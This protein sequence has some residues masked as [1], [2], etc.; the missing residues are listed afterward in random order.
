MRHLL[1]SIDQRILYQV[2]RGSPQPLKVRMQPFEF[3]RLQALI[4]EDK[5]LATV[6]NFGPV[7]TATI[8]NGSLGTSQS[9]EQRDVILS[10]NPDISR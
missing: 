2:A 8:I 10:V 6:M 7:F 9:G 1:N 3:D 5:S 4:A